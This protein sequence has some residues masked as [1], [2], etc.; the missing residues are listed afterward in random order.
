MSPV[1]Q[2]AWVVI[3]LSGLIAPPS[4]AEPSAATAEA[5]LRGIIQKLLD[6]IAPGDAEVWR[7]Y[8]HERLIH[9]D[10]NGIVRTK[11]ELLKELTPLPPGLVGRIVID[12]F[13][14]ETH[15]AIAVVAYDVQEHL[16]F[17]GQ[18]LRSRFR[19]NDTWEKT[20][21]GW[22]LLSEQTTAVLKDPPVIQLAHDQLCSYE[23]SYALTDSIVAQITCTATGLS[24]ERAGRPVVNYVAELADVFYVPGQPR[25]RR[26]FQRDARGRIV[27]FVDRR[28]GEDVKWTRRK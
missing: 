10:E 9:V 11:E 3:S 28:E 26:I 5:E 20:A 21:R 2:A 8:L 12:N 6:A 25:T 27:G 18:I 7:G 24:V 17:Y 22:Q 16:D 14:V 23:G 13:K 19:T 15:A 4:L 1:Q